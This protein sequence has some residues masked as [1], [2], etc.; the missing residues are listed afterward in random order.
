MPDAPPLANASLR[1]VDHSALRVNQT[2]IIGLLIVAFIAN[3]PPL[4]ALVA[5]VMLLGTAVPQAALFKLVYRRLLRP[6]G[7][8]KPNVIADNPEPHRFAQGFGGLVLVMAV[9]A[10]LVGPTWSGWAMVW[11]VVALAGL[12]LFLGFCA[13]CFLYYQLNKFNVPGFDRSPV[14][15]TEQA[16]G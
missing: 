6:A 7:L 11:L 2:F 10:L 5:L 12:N 14:E 1:S 4:V 9:I 3:S 15:S 13:G 16:D 8:V